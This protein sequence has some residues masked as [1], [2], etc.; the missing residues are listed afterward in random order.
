MPTWAASALYLHEL[1]AWK[2]TSCCPETT[3]EWHHTHEV[4][5]RLCHVCI[6]V[7]LL[8]VATRP[9]GEVVLRAPRPAKKEKV[10]SA[11]PI[12][13]SHLPASLNLCLAHL[14]FS[15]CVNSKTNWHH[16]GSA[17]QPCRNKR[18]IVEKPWPLVVEALVL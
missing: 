1:P 13:P 2:P 12:F 6:M 18:H 8:P 9:R 15:K 17:I 16:G 4:M 7:T 14:G 3:L 5:L 10:Q 11:V